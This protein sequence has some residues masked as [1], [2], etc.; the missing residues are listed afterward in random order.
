M[1][2]RTEAGLGGGRHEK[3][4]GACLSGGRGGDKD[5]V[6]GLGGAASSAIHSLKCLVDGVRVELLDRLNDNISIVITFFK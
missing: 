5:L 3:G 1:P 2:N 4:Y 6:T